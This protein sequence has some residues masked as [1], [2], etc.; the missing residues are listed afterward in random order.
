VLP[1]LPSLETGEAWVWTP[2]RGLL[3]RVQVRKARTFDSS[4]TPKPG[5]TA[6]VANVKPIDV[7]ALGAAIKATV[8]RAKENDPAELRK[9][10]RELET[11]VSGPQQRIL[12]ALAALEAIGVGAPTRRSSRCSPRPRR[13]ARPTRTTSAHLN[14]SSA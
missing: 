2:E 11:P 10:I 5:E 1:S 12:N 9:R 8:E 7:D 6:I 14:T 3:E 4:Q 13:R